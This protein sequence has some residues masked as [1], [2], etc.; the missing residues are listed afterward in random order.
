[1]RFSEG[2]VKMARKRALLLLPDPEEIK[3]ISQSVAT[4]DAIIMPEWQLRY[5][6]FNRKWDEDEQVASMRDGGGGFYFAAFDLNGVIIKGYD[7]HREMGAY[8]AR[9]GHPWAGVLDCVPNSFR[10]FL[11]EPAFSISEAT[12]CFWRQPSDSNWN[13]CDIT[14]PSG[15]DPDGS[16]RLLFIFDGDPRTYQ[17]W[18]EGYYERPINLSAIEEVYSHATLNASLVAALNPDRN[19]DSLCEDL[20]EIGYPNQTC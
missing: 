8:N 2:C 9:T 7:P 10:Q 13:M 12:F 19:L 18:A 15:A 3:R 1:M 6:S 17:L 11:S 5:F 20:D 14:F 4:L 16:E